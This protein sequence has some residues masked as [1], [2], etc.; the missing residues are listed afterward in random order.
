MTL[1]SFFPS[2]EAPKLHH[3][4]HRIIMR[5]RRIALIYRI[6]VIA[7][8]DQKIIDFKIVNPVLFCVIPSL[9]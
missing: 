8:L 5:G 2:F 1:C 7:C 3:S 4:V 6:Q 9:I